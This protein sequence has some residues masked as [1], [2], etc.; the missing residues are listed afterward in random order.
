MPK[1]F[2]NM[3]E[4]KIPVWARDKMFR[5]QQ[6]F[7][8]SQNCNFPKES[9][10][11]STFCNSVKP[12]NGSSSVDQLTGLSLS[13]PLLQ[14]K[15]RRL[16]MNF[17]Q[18]TAVSVPLHPGQLRP[19]PHRH[20]VHLPHTLPLPLQLQVRTLPLPLQLQVRTLPLPL[21]LQVR[22][23]PLPLQL[24]VRTLPLPHQLYCRLAPCLYTSQATGQ[25]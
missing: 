22:A 21:Q 16:L 9:F 12:K 4:C 13:V 20:T 24:Q 15:R 1:D 2:S 23:M 3:G 18:H 6:V 5:H 19:C 10:I 7:S 25:D 8:H 14:T 11:L 17:R